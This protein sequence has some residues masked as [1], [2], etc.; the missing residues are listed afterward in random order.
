M[1]NQTEKRNPEKIREDPKVKRAIEDTKQNKNNLS[2]SISEKDKPAISSYLIILIITLLGIFVLWK[3][4][5]TLDEPYKSLLK[6]F[7][8]ATAIAMV[9][10][11]LLKI[12]QSIVQNKV[13]DATTKYNFKRITDLIAGILIFLV[14]LTLLFANWY[15]TLISFG[16]ISLI[17]GLALQNPLSSFFA[18]IYILLRK[19]YE[20]G[21]RI[22]IGSS[23]G[24]VI[25]LGYFDTTLWEFRGDYLS[26]NHPSGRI[27]KFANSKIFDDYIYNYSWPLF[28]YIWNEISFYVSYESD[29]NFVS[30][31]TIN[32]IKKEIGQ[33]MIERVK[34]YKDILKETAIDELEVKD[35]PTVSFSADANTWIKVIAR[36][37]IIPKESGKV[38][39]IIFRNIIDQLS[40]EP[41]KVMFPKTNMR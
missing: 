13:E 9:I 35:E 25:D 24:D 19:P 31:T 21:D 14:F 39:G 36:F 37:L 40:T 12:I 6:H 16:I 33:E 32:V 3:N 34:I 20:V 4:F 15:A 17:L 10:L 11:I 38:K 29:L 2:A 5:L 23:T 7:L 18:W 27:I 28:P 30:E 1:I 41:E 22:K 26:G 8:N